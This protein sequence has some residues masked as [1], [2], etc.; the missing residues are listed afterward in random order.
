MLFGVCKFSTKQATCKYSA[1]NNIELISPG[2]ITNILSI[3]K[4]SYFV[5]HIEFLFNNQY[6][7]LIFII[8]INFDIMYEL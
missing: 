8:K 4:H 3:I 2:C 6:A 1:K 5:N 7:L